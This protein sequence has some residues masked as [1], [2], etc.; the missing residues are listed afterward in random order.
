MAL[1]IRVIE[2]DR[3]IALTAVAAAERVPGAKSVDLEVQIQ[4]KGDGRLQL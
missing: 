3:K 1:G 2:E 4:E